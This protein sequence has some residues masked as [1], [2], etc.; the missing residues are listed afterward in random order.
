MQSTPTTLHPACQIAPVILRI[1]EVQ[2]R[3]GLARPT[4]YKLIQ[5]GRFPAGVDLLGTGR[6]VGWDEQAVSAWI[7]ERI[8]ASSK[9]AGGGQ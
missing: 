1:R 6:C 3:T 4:I 2:A 7:N 9:A 8:S 5:Q